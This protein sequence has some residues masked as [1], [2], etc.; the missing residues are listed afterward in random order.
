MTTFAVK[1]IEPAVCDEL[2][3]RDDAGNSPELLVDA[4]G[5]NP[6]RCCLTLS[7][8]GEE[9]MLASYA[10]LRRWAAASGANPGPYVEV[11]PVFV[12]A[13]PCAGPTTGAGFPPAYR[14]LPRVFRGYDRN[15]RIVGGEHVVDGE[16]PEPAI[17]KVLADPEVAFIHARALI[18]GC[19]TFWIDRAHA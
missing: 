19:F 16:D 10:P 9:I 15:G 1:P 11:G 4:G 2:R 8:P 17:E 14:G 6:L 7:A 13:A 12:H 18:A 5:G 3:V